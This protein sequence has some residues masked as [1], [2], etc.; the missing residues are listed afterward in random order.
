MAEEGEAYRGNHTLRT[1]I[2][3][4]YERQ[5]WKNRTLSD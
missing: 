5:S 1:E 2:E 3:D 4:N